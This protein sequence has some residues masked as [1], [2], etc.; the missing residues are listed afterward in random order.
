MIHKKAKLYITLEAS[1]LDINLDKTSII[2]QSPTGF[3]FDLFTRFTLFSNI[4]F[5]LVAFEGAWQIQAPRENLPA[6]VPVVA[7][8]WLII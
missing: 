8:V 5:I 7:G 2:L 1:R 6:Q 3:H 4:S